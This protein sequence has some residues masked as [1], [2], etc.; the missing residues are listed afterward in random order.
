MLLLKNYIAFRTFTCGKNKIQMNEY[1]ILLL[2]IF[3]AL[4]YKCSKHNQEMIKFVYIVS[5][6]EYKFYLS[7]FLFNV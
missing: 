2:L 3:I 5:L 1:V 6:F 7:F 4:A